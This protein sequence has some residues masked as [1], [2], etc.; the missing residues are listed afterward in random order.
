M[1]SSLAMIAGGTPFAGTELQKSMGIEDSPD[2]LYEEALKV[3]GGSP[4]LWRAIADNHLKVYAWLLSIGAKPDLVL[5]AP[6]HKVRR[7]V[8]FVGHGAGLCKTLKETSEARKLDIRFRN[9]AESLIFDPAKSRVIGVSARSGDKTLNYKAKKG[10][11]LTTGGFCRNI[12]MVKE[13]GPEYADLVP[14][15]PPT[16]MGDGLKMSQEIG[17]ATSNIGLAVCPSMPCDAETGRVLTGGWGGIMINQKAQRWANEATPYLGSYTQTYK[18]LLKMDPTGIHFQIFDEGIKKGQP[19]RPPGPEK[20]VSAD[21]L[22]EL[23]VKVGLD[24]KALRTTVDEYNY[25]IEKY[26]KD[27]KFGRDQQGMAEPGKPARQINNPPYHAIKCKICLTSMKGGLK[28]NGKS[29]V[30]DH[31][32]TVIPGLYAAGEITGGLQGIPAHYYTGT[33]T[34]QAFTQGYIAANNAVAETGS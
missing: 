9:R 8:K 15:A 17:A 28:I 34:L 2:A 21:T 25:D 19:S 20:V 12:D 23:A 13:Y 7:S 26:G 3:S 6:G 33:M 16:H 31:F 30:L 29:Q 18:D 27:R 14:T 1:S 22:E 24:P 10:I 5:Q 4:E 32:G 11:I